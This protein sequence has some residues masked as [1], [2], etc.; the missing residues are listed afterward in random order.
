ME[1]EIRVI[2]KPSEGGGPMTSD[3]IVAALAKV[4]EQLGRV[5]SVTP[6][7]RLYGD[8]GQIYQ[9]V[10]SIVADAEL[11]LPDGAIGELR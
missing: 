6:K 11:D 2:I 1:K 10:G 9:V 3:E 5:S 4:H 8:K 7:I